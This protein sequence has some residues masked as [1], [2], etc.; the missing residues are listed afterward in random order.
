M[1]QIIKRF[2]NQKRIQISISKSRYY[3]DPHIVSETII[4]TNKIFSW[5]T[6]YVALTTKVIT[7][8]SAKGF[9]QRQFHVGLFKTHD[10]HVS[11]MW[12]TKMLTIAIPLNA[13]R[14]I[15]FRCVAHKLFCVDVD[16]NQRWE[17]NFKL[18]ACSSTMRSIWSQCY[19]VWQ[20]LKIYPR[21]LKFYMD[22]QRHYWS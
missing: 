5:A 1:H 10:L 16:D 14:R 4:M 6:W 18:K 11:F 13:P 9:V 19:W 17:K 20:H 12:A 3:P 15:K 8:R 7:S 21:K 2:Y 22:V